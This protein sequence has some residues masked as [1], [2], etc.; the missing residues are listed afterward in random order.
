MTLKD[1][2]KKKKDFVTRQIGNEL[3]LVPVKSNVAQMNELITMNETACFIWESID[4]KNSK[5]DI[6]KLLVEEFDVDKDL[7]LRDL[8]L[9]LGKIAKL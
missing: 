8:D 7:A 6:L 4:G 1:I 9:F 5:E 3:V 2:Y